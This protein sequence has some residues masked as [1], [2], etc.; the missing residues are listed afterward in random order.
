MLFIYLKNFEQIGY[1]K[2]V[3]SVLEKRAVE[4]NAKRIELN[5]FASNKHAV[6]LYSTIGFVEK[7]KILGKRL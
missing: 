5:V 1:G 3:M 2:E 4:L 6:R 7:S